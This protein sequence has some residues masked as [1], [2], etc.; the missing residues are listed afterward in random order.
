MS[1]RR[2]SFVAVVLSSAL[3]GCSASVPPRPVGAP[4]TPQTVTVQNPG[5]DAADPE[6]AAL[7]RLAR[8]PWGVRR[9]RTN[10]LLVPLVDAAHW[11]RVRLWGY[12]TRAAFRF[13][14]DHHG[15]VA[16]WFS[17]TTGPSDPQSCLDRFLAE[18]RPAA[19]AYGTRI[20]ASRPA[21]P[22]PQPSEPFRVG[23]ATEAL[24]GAPS[25]GPMVVQV[26]DA[27]VDGIFSSRGYAGAL[28]AYPSFPGTCLIQ[29][30]V[31]VAS[32]HW[33][34]AS[35][36]RDRWVAEGAPGLAWHPRVT[37]LPRFDDR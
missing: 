13:G 7:D 27:E 15:V 4:P 1:Y 23:L 28:A 9:D 35:R 2:A 25:S 36:I 6:Q 3:L 5:G 17:P 8:E 16:L 26:I 18:A 20:L 32:G 31:V 29:G 22:P 12:P 30:F 14:D 11:Q 24:P 34:L 21:H 37:A 19:E 10:T 33:D